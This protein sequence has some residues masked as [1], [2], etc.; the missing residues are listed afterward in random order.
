M[1]ITIMRLRLVA[2]S[3]NMFISSAGGK[4][5]NMQTSVT[6]GECPVLYMEVIVINVIQS[7][8]KIDQEQ[9]QG[10]IENQTDM[11]NQLC[12]CYL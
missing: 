5:C 12:H 7:T 10:S 11:Q 2:K 4:T 6:E 9:L 3:G 1:R 8:L